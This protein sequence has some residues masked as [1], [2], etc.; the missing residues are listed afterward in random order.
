MSYQLLDQVNLWWK[1]VSDKESLNTYQKTIQTTWNILRET[2]KLAWLFLCL[3]LVLVTW[4]WTSSKESSQQIK[5][6]YEG[7]EEPKSEHIWAEAGQFLLS[8]GRSTANQVM[9][10]ARE[11]LGLPVTEARPIAKTVA[12]APAAKP[13]AA[14]AAPEPEVKTEE[15]S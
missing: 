10:Q 8:T 15:A 3:G 13:A 12:A 6:W 9:T 14:P 1:T 11:Q 5:T 2:A 4:I 7:I